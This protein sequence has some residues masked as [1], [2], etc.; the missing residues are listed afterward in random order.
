MANFL[1]G[2]SAAF[3][4]QREGDEFRMQQAKE[5][6]LQDMRAMEMQ[7][8]Q[9]QMQQ[10][11]AAL[12]RDK[13]ANRN[14]MG[15]YQDKFPSQI[16][17]PP[18]QAA[19]PPMPG[20]A[21]VPMQ[22]NPSQQ[23]GQPLSFGSPPVPTSG[24]WGAI[25]AGVKANAPAMQNDRISILQNELR[26]ETNPANK[27]VLERELSRLGVVH[28]YKSMSGQAQQTEQQQ[29]SQVPPIPKLSMQDAQQWAVSKGIK[30]PDEFVA[31]LEKFQGMLS[32][33]AKGQLAYLAQER[34][35]NKSEEIYLSKQRM[36]AKEPLTQAQIANL[37][38]QVE[39]RGKPN[40]QQAT[41]DGKPFTF[42]QKTGGYEPAKGID[43]TSKVSKIGVDNTHGV[44]G[45]N[46]AQND[47]L[48]GENGAVTTGRLDPNRVNSRTASLFADAAIKNPKTDFSKIHADIALT[49]NAGFRQKTL[50]AETLPEVMQNMVDAG[51]KVGFSDLKSVGKMQSW[52][53]GELNDPDMTEYMTQRNDALM[54][55]A[56]VMRGNGMT[57]MAHKAEI[58]ASSPTMSPKALDAWMRGQMKSLEPR[59][60]NM[61]KIMREDSDGGKKSDSPNNKSDA[62]SSSDTDLINKYLKK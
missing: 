38:S 26:N 13:S 25:N 43:S 58:E 48:F 53:K 28:P 36:D 19:T 41:I 22:Q 7:Q 20:Q 39:N 16:S 57:D 12:A 4:G 60:K 51:K 34:I 18:Q 40:L 29:P 23:N 62:A 37:N 27:A 10:N 17:P 14:V 3:Q 46:D 54:S 42:N 15:F 9:Q 32:N 21:S 47:A 61:R 49:N 45:L 24:G 5:K 33:D 11:Q 30:D 35:N 2:L 44:K 1:S 55:I 59:L 52:L 31:F 50:V 8:Y 6:Q 56:G